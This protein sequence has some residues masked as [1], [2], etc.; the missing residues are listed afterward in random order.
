MS[1]TPLGALRCQAALR[2]DTE[3]QQQLFNEARARLQSLVKEVAAAEAELVKQR[4]EAR[5]QEGKAAAAR[6]AADAAAGELQSAQE[7]LAACNEVH[8]KP[9]AS[10]RAELL[11]LSLQTLRAKQGVVAETQTAY[12]ALLDKTRSL[13]SVLLADVEAEKAKV[14]F[15]DAGA[16]GCSACGFSSSHSFVCCVALQLVELRKERAELLEQTAQAKKAAAA[17]SAPSAGLSSGAGVGAGAGPS[18]GQ[19]SALQAQAQTLA[20]VQQLQQRLTAAELAHSGCAATLA[21]AHERA[22]AAERRADAATE[23]SRAM[24]LRLQAAE[25]AVLQ[26]KQN[27]QQQ[28]LPSA[29]DSGDGAGAGVAGAAGA[30]GAGAG[31]LPGLRPLVAAQLDRERDELGRLREQKRALQAEMDSL[32][33]TALARKHRLREGVQRLQRHAELVAEQVAAKM[34]LAQRQPDQPTA[35]ESARIVSLLQ[36]KVQLLELRG[37]DLM[38][39][40]KEYA[41]SNQ[42]CSLPC[43]LCAYLHVN[44]DANRAA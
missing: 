27:R 18:S 17:A 4:D 33:A 1:L 40:N 11:S 24:E 13:K 3:T 14:G 26:I 5:Q 42:Q 25:Q 31:D 10:R 32:E 29:A 41:V 6:K 15:A 28:Q 35:D 2:K 19:D 30:A 39:L 37:N 23:S 34:S 8:F 38:R 16:G 20:Q 21:Q 22:A 43:R 44:S 9:L 12:D 7:Q 36:R